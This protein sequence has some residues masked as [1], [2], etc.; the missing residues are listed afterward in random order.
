MMKGTLL[1]KVA[2]GLALGAAAAI[3]FLAPDAM[4]ALG[5]MLHGGQ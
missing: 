1:L 4:R 5:R 2:V 3:H